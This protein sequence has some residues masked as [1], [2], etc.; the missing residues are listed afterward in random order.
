MSLAEIQKV[1]MDTIGALGA[2]TKWRLEKGVKQNTACYLQVQH[3]VLTFV[4]QPYK[5]INIC[6]KVSQKFFYNQTN[7]W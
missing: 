7:L 1:S 5:L 4:P 3:N 2:S 6:P